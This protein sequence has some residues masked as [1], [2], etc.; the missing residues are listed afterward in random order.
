MG[1]HK[2]GSLTFH[3]DPN[4][5]AVYVYLRDTDGFRSSKQVEVGE[6]VIVDLDAEGKLIGV[7]LLGPASLN[8]VLTTVVK[9]YHAR[10]L[11]QLER[12]R[13]VIERVFHES[14]TA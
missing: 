11:R 8:I 6:D 3:V 12:S 10:E 2:I 9:K 4:V 14:M 13:D 5:P 7:E 1:Q